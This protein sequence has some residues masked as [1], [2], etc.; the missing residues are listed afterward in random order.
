MSP[1]L[2]IGLIIG[3]IV[4]L[5]IVIAFAFYKAGFSVDKIKAKL[6]MFEMEASRKKDEATQTDNTAP[7]AGPKISQ[8][9]EDGGAISGSG[10]SAPADAAA[11]IDQQAKGQKSKIDDS[12]I[13]LT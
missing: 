6:P 3:A 4:I 12:P 2:T 9:A 11:D 13:N 1:V 7:V 8:R 5:V 10:I